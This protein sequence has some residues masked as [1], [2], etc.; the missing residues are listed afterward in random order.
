[1]L[2]KRGEAKEMGRDWCRQQESNLHLSLRRTLYY[3]LYYGDTLRIAVSYSTL[4]RAPEQSHR[5]QGIDHDAPGTHRYRDHVGVG[6]LRRARRG[7][8]N[9]AGARLA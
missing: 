5:W 7:R 8:R 6:A 3:P 1:M 4:P 9:C 2:V